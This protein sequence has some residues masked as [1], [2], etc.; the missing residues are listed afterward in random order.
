MMISDV[1]LYPARTLAF[2]AGADDYIC[3][4]AGRNEIISRIYALLQRARSDPPVYLTAGCIQ[5]NPREIELFVKGKQ[6]RLTGKE[7]LS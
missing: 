5:M 6:V 1:P 4:P 3:H 7:S 2:H